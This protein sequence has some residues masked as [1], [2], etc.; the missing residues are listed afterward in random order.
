FDGGLDP[1]LFTYIP[2]PGEQVRPATPVVERL[3]LEAAV[4]RLPFTIL[5]PK[6]GIEF[7]RA[8]LDTW[9]CP[10]RKGSERPYFTIMYHLGAHSESLWIHE[11]Q[12]PDTSFDDYEWTR[13]D[14]N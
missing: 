9:Y 2:E 12:F 7:D 14:L 11:S 13:F 3:T 6:R 5:V 4:A 10:S 1:T 8:L